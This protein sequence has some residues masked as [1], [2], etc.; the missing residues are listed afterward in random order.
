MIISI[1]WLICSDENSSELTTKIMDR[2]IIYKVISRF[3]IIV[4]GNF[5]C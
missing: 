1:L 3:H 2:V 4:E 5:I